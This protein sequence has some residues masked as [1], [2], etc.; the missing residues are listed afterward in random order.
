MSRRILWLLNH[1]TLRDFEV[2]MLLDMGFEVFTPKIYQFEYGDL[3]ASVTWEYDSSLS[4]PTEDLEFLN[5]CDMYADRIPERAVDI[6]N[7][8]F[9]IAIF[10]AFVPQISMLVNCF[11]GVL[12][13]QA[14]GLDQSINY[15]KLF[16][17]RNPSLLN[18]ICKLNDRFWFGA[19]YENLPEVECN[20]FKKQY[21]YLPIGLKRD[22]VNSIWVGG[23]ERILFIG[24]K[25][26]TNT[27]YRNVYKSFKRDFGMIPHVIGGAQMIPVPDDPAVVGFLPKEEYEYNMRHLAAMFYHSQEPRHLHYHP[28]EAVVNGMPLVFMA[29]GMLDNIGGKDLPGRCTT[30]VQ[31]RDMLKRLSRG[32]SALARKI[33]ERQGCLLNTFRKDFCKRYWVKAFERFQSISASDQ[34]QHAKTIFKCKV[35]IVV[36]AEYTGGVLDFSIRLALAIH[37][38][39]VN[40]GDQIEIVFY[41]LDLP[42]YQEKNYFKSLRKAGIRVQKYRWVFKQN[43]WFSTLSAIKGYENEIL[44]QCGYVV[45]DGIQNLQD[46]DYCIFTC[47]RMPY[48][49]FPVTPYGIVVHDVIQRYVPEMFDMSYEVYRRLN[50]D[51]ADD[52]VVT[53]PYMAATVI[54]YFGLP[55]EKVTQIPP[56]YE[57]IDEKS[58]NGLVNRKDDYFIWP[59]NTSIHKNHIKALEALSKYYAKGG[60]LKCYV[61]GAQ[62]NSFSPHFQRSESVGME[63]DYVKKVRERIKSDKN[64][65]NFLKIMGELERGIYLDYLADAKFVFHPGYADNGNGSSVEALQLGVPTVTTQYP[66]MEYINNLMDAHMTL[67]DSSDPDDMADKLLY[68]EE[69]ASI[70]AKDLPSRQEL[71]PFLLEGQSVEIYKIIR[72]M[73]RGY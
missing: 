56:L 59:T 29:G 25:I 6:I 9:G 1:T 3:S 12:V 43:E 62:T 51:R 10:G 15:T 50:N 60:K 11:Q 68:M 22:T 5:Q 42:V 16:G 55:R 30:I 67:F 64:L 47:D 41:H 20:Y 21:V 33:V 13:F 38:G 44:P 49:S 54:N 18:A 37:Q 2:P 40:L 28:L 17:Y 45:E 34:T 61:T 57:V 26:N 19:T 70:I 65:K 39:A 14:F 53:T 7:K 31:A 48:P 8:Y 4:I 35:A 32:D 58:T 27:Y 63:S 23:D 69:N 24:P 72:T 36:P 66:P 73:I 46:F 52:I 71:E